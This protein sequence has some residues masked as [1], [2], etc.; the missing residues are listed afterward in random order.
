MRKHLLSLLLLI[1]VSSSTARAAESE[2]NDTWNTADV[3]TAG[4]AQT[5]TIT[6]SSDIDW[7]KLRINQDGQINFSGGATTTGCLT[8]QLFDTLG[9]IAVNGTIF[10]CGGISNQSTNGLAAGTFY[11]KII[12]SDNNVN[13]SFTLT[14]TAATPA[15]D[16]EPN[17][18]FSTAI[19][20]ALNGSNTGHLGYYFNNKRDSI[21]WYKIVTTANGA[22]KLSYTG[23]S[24]N[25]VYFQLFDNNGTTALNAEVF[26]CGSTNNQTTDGL[27]PGTYYVRIRQGSGNEFVTYTLS[28]S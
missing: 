17:N 14:L 18:T 19:T 27:A 1:I 28:N 22:L 23:N 8:F 5:G 7:F 24:G 6:T 3:L 15:I 9:T 16:T 20:Q 2:P 21:D 25:C 4:V 12:S 11:L 13:Y 26:N 10:N